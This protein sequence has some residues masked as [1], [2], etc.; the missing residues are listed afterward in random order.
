MGST[1]PS[2]LFPVGRPAGASASRP[3][4]PPPIS[5]CR[6]S[7]SRPKQV[8]VAAAVRTWDSPPAR[9]ATW[10][11]CSSSRPTSPKP[12][13]FA[14]A[15]AGKPP[16]GL[17]ARPP[18]RSSEGRHLRRT[19]PGASLGFATCAIGRLASHPGVMTNRSANLL[20]RKTRSQCLLSSCNRRRSPRPNA[21]VRR[22]RPASSQCHGYDSRADRVARHPRRSRN[23]GL[24][25][26]D[27]SVRPR[28]G[29]DSCAG[30]TARRMS[31]KRE[32]VAAG[33]FLT[34]VGRGS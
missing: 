29:R 31:P 3:P 30:R 9:L 24:L 21:I 4:W 8:S 12:C 13:N 34:D 2:N 17:A 20:C 18:S 27:G 32:R 7:V 1:E 16:I 5:D 11:T 23:C 14:R 10:S 22:R 28:D 15:G 25:T 26:T 6:S 19:P 33:G